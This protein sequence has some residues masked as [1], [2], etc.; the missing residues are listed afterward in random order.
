MYPRKLVVKTLKMTAMMKL[1][2]ITTL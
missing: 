1:T 2:I